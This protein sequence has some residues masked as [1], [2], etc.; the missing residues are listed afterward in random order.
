MFA[1]ILVAGLILAASFPAAASAFGSEHDGEWKVNIETTAG[2]GSCPMSGTALVTIR[3]GLV[4][5]VSTPG[6]SPW[7]YV[8][9][10]TFVGHF[11]EGNQMLRANGDVKGDFAYGPW[12]SDTNFCGGRWTARKVR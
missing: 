5:G 9:G 12:S 6:V 1:R 4:V 10:N 7:G 11:S 2:K 3:R 8:D